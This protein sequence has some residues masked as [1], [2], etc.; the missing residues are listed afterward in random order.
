[1]TTEFSCSDRS[2]FEN[3]TGSLER[4]RQVVESHLSMRR[5][6]TGFCVACD[7]ISTFQIGPTTHPSGWVNLREMIVCPGCG[8]SGR[9]RQAFG[10][11]ASAYYD[12]KPQRAHVFERVTPLY[13]ALQ[14]RDIPIQGS[15]YIG[16]D[17][18]SGTHHVRGRFEIMHQDMHATSYAE[19]ELDL[20]CHFDVLEHVADHRR[21]LAECHRIL[22][23][24]GLLLFTVP[25]FGAAE[26]QV[27]SVLV[28]GQLVHHH[29]PAYHGNPVSAEGSLVF[30]VPGW[31]LLDVLRDIGFVNVEIGL[32]Y[33]PFQGIVCDNNPHPNNLMWPIFFRAR[34]RG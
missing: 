17:V 13:A 22:R 8:L 2:V 10:L 18:E 29:P 19:N 4:M 5:S 21:A 7:S 9:G 24:G 34:K 12:L 6:L 20:V 27:R 33:D 11:V 14:K 31:P 28:D 26:T 30:F 15:E 25:F 16:D 3:K 23:P 32:S 1:M